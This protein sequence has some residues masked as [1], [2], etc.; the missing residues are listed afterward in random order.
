ME[1]LRKGGRTVLFVSHSMSAVEGLC[2]RVIWINDGTIRMDG[3]AWNVIRAYMAAFS[4]EQRGC[5]E[6]HGFR[7][8]AGTGEIRLP[9]WN[10]FLSHGN[11]NW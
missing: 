9:E 5:N 2:S 11:P 10:F 3:S 4:N 6:L 8:R 1:D 7:R